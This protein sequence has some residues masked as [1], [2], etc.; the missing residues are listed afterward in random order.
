MA[1]D[2]GRLSWVVLQ[3]TLTPMRS[4]IPRGTSCWT[5]V[6]KRRALAEPC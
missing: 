1:L 2:I 4:L 6:D 3:G 5:D